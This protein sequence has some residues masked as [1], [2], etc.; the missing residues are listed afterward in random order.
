MSYRTHKTLQTYWDA[1]AHYNLKDSD[2]SHFHRT[3]SV[4]V[5]S[6]PQRVYL[7]T[8]RNEQNIYSQTEDSAG[9]APIMESISGSILE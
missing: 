2:V 3:G 7:K 1:L 6:T 5:I 4:L 9:A 8:V